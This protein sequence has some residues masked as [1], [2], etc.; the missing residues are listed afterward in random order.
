M[1][2]ARTLFSTGL[3]RIEVHVGGDPDITPRNVWTLELQPGRDGAGVLQDFTVAIG[4]VQRRGPE[5]FG[6]ALAVGILLER[7]WEEVTA[8]EHVEQQFV[9]WV[10]L[11]VAEVLYD[12]ARRALQAQAALMDFQFD[13]DLKAP[14]TEVVVSRD[15][16]QA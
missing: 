9:E 11:N 12:T 15:A 2:D 3:Q 8:T 4:Y 1:T 7:P 16:V 5:G 10:R 14:P 13:L 6:Q